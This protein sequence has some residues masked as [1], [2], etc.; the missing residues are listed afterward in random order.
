MQGGDQKITDNRAATTLCA[1]AILATSILLGACSSVETQSFVVSESSQVESAQIA[2][3]ADFSKF[4]RLQAQEMGIFF[5]TGVAMRVA[6][7]ERLRQAFRT[8]FVAE[9]EGYSI[10]RDPGPTTLQV[11][12]SLI[13]LRGSAGTDLASL[14][15]DVRDMAT[16]GSLVFLMEMK[17]SMTGEVLARAADSAKAPALGTT[18]N[19]K[20]DWQAVD[21]AA[22]HW[23][24]LF[25]EFLD[26]NLGR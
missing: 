5:P 23:A 11:Q 16:A 13:D 15:R 9:L 1:A 21:D 6:D 18:N 25:R 26:Q 3:G 24:K 14:R 20:T 10:S 2:V 19:A 4:D 12:A 22:R 8:A 17:D 7:L